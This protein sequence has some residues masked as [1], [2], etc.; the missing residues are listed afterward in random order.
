MMDGAAASN[1]A[2]AWTLE[3]KRAGNDISQAARTLQA[4]FEASSE[5]AVQKGSVKWVLVVLTLSSS[6]CTLMLFNFI[7]CQRSPNSRS[8]KITAKNGCLGIEN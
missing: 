3:L 7:L 8:C 6:S 5:K 2:A 1:A 4:V